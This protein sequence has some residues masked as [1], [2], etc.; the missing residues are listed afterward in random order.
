MDIDG[1]DRGDS[2]Q[3]GVEAITTTVGGVC[4]TNTD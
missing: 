1:D 4:G 2:L 3:H